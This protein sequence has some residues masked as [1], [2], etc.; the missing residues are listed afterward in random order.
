MAEKFD[1]K[2]C[3]LSFLKG[4]VYQDMRFLKE[5]SFP[6]IKMSLSLGTCSDMVFYLKK[7]SNLLR[8]FNGN[9][10][11]KPLSEGIFSSVYYLKSDKGNSLV[12]KKSHDGWIP[13]RIFQGFDIPLPRWLIGY[14]YD[15]YEISPDS[16]LRDVYDY[17]KVIRPFWGKDRVSVFS[18]EIRKFI[19]LVLHLV[20]SNLPKFSVSDLHTLKFWDDMLK[21]DEHEL[22][23]KFVLQMKRQAVQKS[24]IPE[25]ERFIFYDPK[26]KLLQSIFIQEAKKGEDEILPDK[27]MVFPFQLVAEGIIPEEL[28]VSMIDQFIRVPYSFY[29]QLKASVEIAKVPDYRPHE[30]WKLFPPSPVE[31][32]VSETNNLV[33]Y[34]NSKGNFEVSFV[35]TQILMEHKSNQI[36]EWLEKRFWNSLFLNLRFW[37]RNILKQIKNK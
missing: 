13:F 28:P 19:N 26:S 3:D 9:E 29:E 15:D 11:V 5:N 18:P 25:E 21:K 6:D 20:D 30:G 1:P 2:T 8:N 22:L 14:F 36:Y 31:L 35:D 27:F 32:Y 24:L 34:K 33:V 12:L 10:S 37:A 7:Y 4:T 16:L 17:E 23:D